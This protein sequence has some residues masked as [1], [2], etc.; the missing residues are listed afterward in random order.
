MLIAARVTIGLVGLGAI[1]TWIAAGRS[2][3]IPSTPAD[4]RRAEFSTQ[5]P[6]Q[7]VEIVDLARKMTPFRAD[8]RP[9]RERYGAAEPL[10]GPIAASIP[11]PT[12][13]LTGILTGREPAAVVEGLP[14][15]EGAIVVRP[16]ETIGPLTVVKINSVG[17]TIRGLDTAWTLTVRDPWH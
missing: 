8:R 10:P 14:G 1:A 5:R 6:I 2:V 3:P 11:R 4:P 13:V 9:S 7:E 12:L 15:S 17:V 16:G